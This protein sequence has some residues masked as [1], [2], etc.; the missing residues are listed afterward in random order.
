MNDHYLSKE[1][2]RIGISYADW[3]GFLGDTDRTLEC[4]KLHDVNSWL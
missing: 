1:R 4:S 2:Q 3:L